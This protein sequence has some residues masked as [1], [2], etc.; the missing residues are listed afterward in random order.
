MKKWFIGAGILLVLLIGGYFVLSL[1][2]VKFIQPRFQKV[3]GP[4]LTV[5]KIEIK[6]T[7]LSAAKIEYEDPQSR[8]KFLKIEEVRIYPNLLSFLKGNLKVR[9]LLILRP[10]FYFYRSREGT[11]VGP[12]FPTE[13]REK[14]Q[15]IP[16]EGK[17]GE[18]E[19]ISIEID[20]IQIKQ[21]SIDFE[22]QKFG[23]S[24]PPLMLRDLDFRLENIRYPI[25]SAPSPLELRGKI[26]GRTKEGEVE[27][28]GW[29]DLQTSDLETTFKVQGIEVKTFEPY[30]KKRVTAEIDSG[31]IHLETKITV[32]QKWMDAPGYLE[33]FDL[34]VKEEGTVFWIP[35][36]TLVSLL[37]DKGN[38]IKAQFHV[39]GNINDPQFDLQ[40]NVLNRIGFSLAEALGIPIKGLGETILGGAGKGAEGLA[41]GLRGIGEMFKK[42]GK[43][44]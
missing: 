42:K 32:K 15:R 28:K 6:T 20:R 11:F 36:K 9:E 21:G 4:G 16:T 33:L 13:R 27:A 17:K 5:T 3:M 24:Q 44:K 19:S 41:E 18:K 1:Y 34:R 40:E 38:R 8:Q 7:Y 26:E 39:K 12:W 23:K 10:S 2:A 22:D 37:K 30:Y 14:D 25:V 29:I 31:T 35:A 43:K